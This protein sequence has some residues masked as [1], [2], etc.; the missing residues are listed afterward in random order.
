VID[1]TNLSA[2]LIALLKTAAILLGLPR[3]VVLVSYLFLLLLQEFDG[4]NV[5]DEVQ[6][7]VVDGL[8]CLLPVLHEDLVGDFV[9]L[10][11]FPAY[12]LRSHE[13]VDALNFG[14]FLQLDHFP[15]GAD[16]HVTL[17]I[18]LVVDD[19]E[20]VLADKEDL[21]GWHVGHSEYDI[22]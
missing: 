20:D 4:L 14:E 15:S 18:G 11:Q 22:A 7:H 19:C 17:Y 3:H 2:S 5:R 16:Q 8:P 10:L 21:C 6:V 12:F 9:D 1:R 13:E